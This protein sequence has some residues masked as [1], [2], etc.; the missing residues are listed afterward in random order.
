MSR[1]FD[2]EAYER[3]LVLLGEVLKIGNYVSKTSQFARHRRKQRYIGV[4]GWVLN[5]DQCDLIHFGFHAP[6]EFV[7]AVEILLK[8]DP[9]VENCLVHKAG[10]FSVNDMRCYMNLRVEIQFMPA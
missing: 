9:R 2:V 1:H 6:G 8:R 4:D 3:Q 10:H 7:T 5:P